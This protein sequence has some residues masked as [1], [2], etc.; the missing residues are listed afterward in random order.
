[1]T[2]AVANELFRRA[3]AAAAEGSFDE[4][5]R[6]YERLLRA[7]IEPG[8]MLFR[9]GVVAN[10]QGR[11]PDAWEYHT[12]A[13]AN[14]PKLAARVAPPESPYQ[15]HTCS[16]VYDQEE[17]TSC[18]VCGE[19][20][21]SLMQVVNCLT[22]VTYHP[23]LAPVRRWLCCDTC[24]HGYVSPRPTSAALEQ[25]YSMTPPETLLGVDYYPMSRYSDIVHRFW[26]IMP[27]GELLDIGA[28]QCYMASVAMDYGYTATAMDLLPRYKEFADR[29][30]CEFILGDVTTY[31]F[32]DRQFDIVT[33][34]DVIEHVLDPV[35]VIQRMAKLLR[36]TGLL[37]L[38]TPNHE[39]AWTRTIRDKDP[40][41]TESQHVQF[42]SL[43]SLKRLMA[44]CG[45]TVVDYRMSQHWLGCAQVIARF[46]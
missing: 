19:T 23:A 18:P 14:N 5:N 7:G 36:P 24:G 16:G 26:E 43:R 1:M 32:G 12:A 28:A 31:D 9:L 45:L 25:V 42:F 37:W 15:D 38:S 22:S 17:A 10:A 27:G 11:L 35:S 4:A 2:G 20:S 40:M 8:L 21:A 6:N 13:V 34:G 41:W 30:G 33:A 44:D 46:V 3:E 39:G 29:V